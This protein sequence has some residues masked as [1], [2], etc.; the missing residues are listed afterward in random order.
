MGFNE[1]ILTTFE[2][3]FELLS[4]RRGDV[5]AILDDCLCKIGTESTEMEAKF[6]GKGW[7]KKVRDSVVEERDNSESPG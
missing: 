4:A 1:R 3:I 2:C 6:L 7:L 5:G